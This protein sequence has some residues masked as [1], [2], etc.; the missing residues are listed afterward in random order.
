MSRLAVN[1]FHGN[2]KSIAENGEDVGRNQ[3]DIIDDETVEQPQ[4]HSDYQD[5]RLR[6]YLPGNGGLLAAVA[7]MCAG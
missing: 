1:Y 5:D 6:V 2:E 3:R 7:M 4:P